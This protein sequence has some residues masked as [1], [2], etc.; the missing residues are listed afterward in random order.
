[1][2]QIYNKRQ[3]QSPLDRGCG[4]CQENQTDSVS[5]D[6]DCNYHTECL[7]QSARTEEIEI[8]RREAGII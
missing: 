2:E 6:F 1:M 5:K 8:F 7:K 4:F 3:Y